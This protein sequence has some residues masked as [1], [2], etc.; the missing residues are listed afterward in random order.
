MTANNSMVATSILLPLC[1]VPINE[2]V[3][4]HKLPEQIKG[5]SPP[6]FQ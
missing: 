6:G 3:R 5:G 4:D 1:V 2:E